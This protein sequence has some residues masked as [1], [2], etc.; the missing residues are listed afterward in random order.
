MKDS[1]SENR[2]SASSWRAEVLTIAS[3]GRVTEMEAGSAVVEN[4]E[5]ETWVITSLLSPAAPLL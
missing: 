3:T 2:V 1:F 5:V 4:S